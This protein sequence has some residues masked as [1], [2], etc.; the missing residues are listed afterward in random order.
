[1]KPIRLLYLTYNE[2]PVGSGILRVQVRKMLEALVRL[3][4]I[5][6]V[7]LVSFISPRLKRNQIEALAKLEKELESR[8]IE[9]S[10]RLMPAATAWGW[11]ALLLMSPFCLPTLNKEIDDFR[12][13]VLHSRSYAAGWLAHKA[14]TTRKIPT[15]FDP[16][17][18]YPEEMVANGRWRSKGISYRIWKSIEGRLV[19]ESGAVV[20]VTP[21]YR[22][23]FRDREAVKSVFIPNRC[24]LAAFPV[25]ERAFRTD[26][27]LM[28]FVGEMDSK[29]YSP[30][31]IGRHF[32]LL[33]RSIPNLR[34][35][36]V[37]R[38][39]PAYIREGFRKIGIPDE[40]W[41][42]KGVPPEDVP[43]L[44]NRA[45]LGLVAMDKTNVW[46]V[47]FAEYLA[48]GVPVII[49][50]GAG[51][52]ICSIVEKKRLGIVIDIDEPESYQSAVNLLSDLPA[53]RK[54][55]R[56]YAVQRLSIESTARQYRRLYRSVAGI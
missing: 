47:K 54:R 3:E 29:W 2:N 48:A 1:M 44:L 36:V 42:S 23:E 16:R 52:L 27:P 7:R 19:Q 37:T 34:F 30:E 5:E 10:V 18:P 33:R 4:G 53:Y 41:E 11:P 24:D 31:Y 22:D 35:L 15:I 12:P 13:T 9:F 56:D 43:A 38:R 32:L 21:D 17:G 28:A 49:H 39:D 50:R 46:P 25:L 51:R 40:A 55:C 45:S 26:D 8:H 6:A 20:G 14:S